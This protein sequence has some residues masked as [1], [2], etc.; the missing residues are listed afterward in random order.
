MIKTSVKILAV[1]VLILV[2]AAPAFS[3]EVTLIGKV[4]ESYQIETDQG[5]VYDVADTD[6]GNELLNHVG[7]TVEVTG[8]ISEEEGVKII[9]VIA[10]MVIEK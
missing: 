8:I 10:Y 7:E 6:M 4:N 5:D 2:L 9:R 1:L 3:T